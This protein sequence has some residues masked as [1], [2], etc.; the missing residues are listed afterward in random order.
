MVSGSGE[1]IEFMGG[2]MQSMFGVWRFGENEAI[3]LGVG[4]STIKDEF[5]CTVGILLLVL[6]CFLVLTCAQMVMMAKFAIFLFYPK[7]KAG[8]R[9]F[10]C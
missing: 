6:I 7:V 8:D 3:Y 5:F 9:T 1:F 2:E 4:I 10:N